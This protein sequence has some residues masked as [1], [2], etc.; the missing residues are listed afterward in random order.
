MGFSEL[1]SYRVD[2]RLVRHSVEFHLRKP[3]ALTVANYL[4]LAM[5]SGRYCD[6]HLV[7]HV[8]DTVSRVEGLDM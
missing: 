5:A 3:K 1:N 7:T 6:I 2:P 8:C 4:C